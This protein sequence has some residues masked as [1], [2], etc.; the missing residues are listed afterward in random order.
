MASATEE[1]DF[2]LIVT[3]LNYHMW[4][5]AIILDSGDYYP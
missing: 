3:N 5:V 1:L 4:L 2:Y